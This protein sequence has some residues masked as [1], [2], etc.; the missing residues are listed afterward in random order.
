MGPRRLGSSDQ[1]LCTRTGPICPRD[2]GF[3]TTMTGPGAET[4][5]AMKTSCSTP[6]WC[7]RCST[8]TGSR[9]WPAAEGEVEGDAVGLC[10]AGPAVDFDARRIHD[11]I[12][13]RVRDQPPMEPEPFTTGLVATQNRDIRRQAEAPLRRRDLQL[14]PL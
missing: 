8:N 12:L 5:S 3:H 6:L 1:I 14:E 7:Q 10:P 4:T 9:A 11:Q 2:D 13:H